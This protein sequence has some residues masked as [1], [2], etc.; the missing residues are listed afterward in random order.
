[1]NKPVFHFIARKT[2]TKK[3]KGIQREERCKQFTHKGNTI[4]KQ[5][6]EK[7][8]QLSKKHHLCYFMPTLVNYKK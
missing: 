6:Y 8:S 5:I 1:M 7:H 4:S 2:L 3:K